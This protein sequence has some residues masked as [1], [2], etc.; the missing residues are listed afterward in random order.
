MPRKSAGQHLPC[1]LKIRLT[2]CM[3]AFISIYIIIKN[4]YIK[5]WEKHQTIERCL[6]VR[7]N[8]LARKITSEYNEN[9]VLCWEAF[10]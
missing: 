4:M 9:S 8:N 10:D 5:R 6:I 2:L 1:S 3:L 7:K